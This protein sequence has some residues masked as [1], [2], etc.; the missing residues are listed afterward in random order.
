M[1]NEVEA[2]RGREEPQRD[3]HER[4]Y[5]V[6]GAGAGGA[7]EGLQLC[8]RQFDRIEVGTVGGQKAE[9]RADGFDGRLHLRLLVHREVIEYHHVARAERRHQ[10]LLDVGEEGG[11]IERAVEDSGGRETLNAERRD[12]RVGLPMAARCVIPQPQAARA[13]AVAAQQIGG[14]ARLVEKDI[15]ARIVQGQR[16]LPPATRGGNIRATLFVGVYRFF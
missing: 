8:K 11:V 16:V 13:A 10:D 14:D 12:H 6:K 9:P 5:L 3:R 4:D 1:P 15:A 2:F 7:Q